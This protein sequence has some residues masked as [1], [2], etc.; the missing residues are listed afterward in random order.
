M[1]AT[2]TK[3]TSRDGTSIGCRCSGNGP[4]LL[5]VHGGAGASTR[6]RPILPGLE[7]HF[8]VYAMDRRGR[9]ES[10]DSTGD[11]SFELE[12]GDVAAL[13]N[14]IEGPVNLY[15]HSGG[16]T[17][18]LEAAP[19]I[20]NLGKL[21][22]YEGVFPLGGNLFPPTIIDRLQNLL[23]Q[24]EH[25]DLVVTFMREV[26]KMPQH[27]IDHVR[28]SP[29]WPRRVATAPTLPRELRGAN[30]YQFTP[31]RFKDLHVQ[32]LLLVGS[33]SPEIFKKSAEI[34]HDALSNSR[35]QELPGQQH[36]A[37]LMAPEMVANALIGFLIEEATPAD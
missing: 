1:E 7:A 17:F 5:L 22:L 33:D 36:L 13:A 34:V 37:D 6:W 30:N 26:P 3:V 9:G 8:S 28:S 14:S 16:G 15:G 35:V 21:V 4:P 32:T 27:E 11:Y 12:A 23:D 24:G 31:E 20:Q 10:G 29:E 18:V 19:Q 25:E 2:I